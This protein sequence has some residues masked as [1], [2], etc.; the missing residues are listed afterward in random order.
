MYAYIN[1]YRGV[2]INSNELNFPKNKD[3]ITY[4]EGC[5]KL[6]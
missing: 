2:R 5:L 3:K 1:L 6:T 4:F